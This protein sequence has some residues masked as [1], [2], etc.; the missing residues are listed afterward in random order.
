M[1]Q[2]PSR[3]VQIPWQDL[4]CL[5]QGRPPPDIADRACPG[6]VPPDF[7]ALRSLAQLRAGQ[8]PLWCLGFYMVADGDGCI[9]GSCG[10][11]GE[12][13]E[14]LVEIGYG[15]SP[16]ARLQGH[17]GSAVAQLIAIAAGSLRVR[18]VL[19]QVNP[20]NLAS[21]RVVQKLGFSA[22]GRQLDHEGE[23]LVQWVREIPSTPS[24]QETDP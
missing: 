15:V 5:A 12:P 24:L 4:A 8:S 13:L 20:A 3:L 14:G 1:P 21:T 2:R 6:A 17:A 7:V 23:M 19:A 11:K 22:R 16:E 18:R 9:V 10:F